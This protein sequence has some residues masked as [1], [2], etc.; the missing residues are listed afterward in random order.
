MN[1]EKI[2]YCGNVNRAERLGRDGWF[3]GWFVDG[4]PDRKTEQFEIKSWH[5]DDQEHLNKICHEE[6]ALKHPVWECARSSLKEVQREK[7][8]V[9]Q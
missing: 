8:A 9:K 3:V 4:D 7:S 2:R 6:K 5:F 1:E